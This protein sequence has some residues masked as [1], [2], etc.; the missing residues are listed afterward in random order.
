MGRDGRRLTAHGVV[1]AGG[2]RGSWNEVSAL[3]VRAG[4]G[5]KAAVLSWAGGHQAHSRLG[6]S[7]ADT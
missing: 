1:G 7:S 3:Q 2:G 6:H 5:R 4:M